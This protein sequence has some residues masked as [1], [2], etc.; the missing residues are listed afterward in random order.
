[1]KKVTFNKL[2]IFIV[3]FL[4]F[5]IC[6]L[7]YNIKKSNENIRIANKE[8]KQ[9]KLYCDDV[10]N[11]LK[12]SSKF[13]DKNIALCQE[14]LNKIDNINSDIIEYK[15]KIQIMNNYIYFVYP[16]EVF[17]SEYYITKEDI[18]ELFTSLFVVL[19]NTDLSN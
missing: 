19:D 12:N 13:N 9:S 4:L 6:F 8:F 5:I 1:M 2:I 16:Y 17:D 18:N 7:F 3:I 11:D 10:I 15:N 14:K